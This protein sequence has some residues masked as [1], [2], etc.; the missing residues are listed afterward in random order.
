MRKYIYRRVS[1]RAK[2]RSI[3]TGGD[4]LWSSRAKLVVVRDLRIYRS[5][6]DTM[7]DVYFDRRTWNTD[8]DGLIYTDKIWLAGVQRMLRAAG[9]GRWRDVGYTEHGMQGSDYVSLIAGQW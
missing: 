1:D 2:G 4:G 7:L 5:G 6:D 3:Q 9:F 8:T